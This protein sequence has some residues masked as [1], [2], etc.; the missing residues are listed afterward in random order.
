MSI[1]TVFKTEFK[2]GSILVD[3]YTANEVDPATGKF[4]NYL[5][6]Q[7][8]AA[9]IGVNEST[10]RSK[11]LPK[12]LEA[13]LGAGFTTRQGQYKNTQKSFSKM[14]LWDTTSA[15]FYYLYHR[16]HG[17]KIA[18]A[19]VTALIATTLD[20]IIDDAFH[21]V[22]E[23]GS[24]QAKTNARLAGMIT[25][26][27]LTDA[28]KAYMESHEVSENYRKF[29]YSNCSDKINRSLFGKTAA[30]LCAERSCS[31]DEL[32]DT[33]STASLALIDR[34]E[35]HAVKLIDRGMEPQI[36]TDDAVSFYS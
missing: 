23:K 28:I 6:G 26:R 20:I 36:A 19:I 33:H 27:T 21:R 12:G 30:K 35:G 3:G 9:S 18:G 32:R 14:N 1:I 25:R 17:N 15:A 2:I 16:D 29:V 31:K 10:T 11:R 34:I 24:A 5:S 8:L 22:Y 4:I 7:G 13:I